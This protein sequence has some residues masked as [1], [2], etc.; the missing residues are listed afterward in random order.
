MWTD[1]C[2]RFCSRCRD[3]NAGIHPTPML[4]LPPEQ[5]PITLTEIACY[6]LD[7]ADH[8]TCGELELTLEQ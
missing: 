7:V 3:A 6:G 4:Q 2:H 5:A 8:Q 1:R